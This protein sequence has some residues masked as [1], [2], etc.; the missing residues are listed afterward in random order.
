MAR[1][2]IISIP[3]YVSYTSS[4][5]TRTTRTNRRRLLPWPSAS[6]VPYTVAAETDRAS[7]SR[8]IEFYLEI[9]LDKDNVSL[10]YALAGKMKT[11]RDRQAEYSQVRPPVPP[12][13]FGPFTPLTPPPRFCLRRTSTPSANTLSI[14]FKSPPGPIPGQLRVFLVTSR[15]PATF[16][17]RCLVRR[18]SRKFVCP[19]ST[20]ISLSRHSDTWSPTSL[21]NLIREYLPKEI[22]K[23]LKDRLSRSEKDVRSR[24][25]HSHACDFT[26]SAT[27]HFQAKSGARRPL[28]PAIARTA[29]KRRAPAK[30]VTGTSKAKR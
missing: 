1:L 27:F 6:F 23:E 15:C 19:Q 13:P 22:S 8:Y 2:T 26:N 7:P 20:A 29:V 30:P 9:I 21:Q 11:I 17:P 3:S 24:L 16:S 25:H 12:L 10:L 28:A 5:T 18:R 4:P 14:S